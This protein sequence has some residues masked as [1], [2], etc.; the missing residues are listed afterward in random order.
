M[1]GLWSQA[2]GVVGVAALAALWFA[3]Q[4]AWR[5]AFPEAGGDPDPLAG[6]LGCHGC[7]ECDTS[8][9][10]ERPAGAPAAGEE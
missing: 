10:R 6:R 7:G 5:R 4:G 8:C 1:T 2:A 9:G 3:V